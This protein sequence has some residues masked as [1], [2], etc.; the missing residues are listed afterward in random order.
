GERPEGRGGNGAEFLGLRELKPGDDRRRVHWVKSAAAGRLLAV[1]RE[2]ERKRRVV[3][4]LDNRGE[5]DD[6]EWLEPMVEEAAALY[7]LL[8]L[9][10]LEVGLSVSGRYLPPEGGVAALKSR[11][12]ELAAL[13]AVP[14]SGP[15]PETRGEGVIVI[16][17]VG[18]RAA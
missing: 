7:R 14:S 6:P 16:A 17:R 1:E 5:P 11:L 9:R 3:L 4:V 15:A 13:G 8:A 10:G 12:R 2:R 18:R